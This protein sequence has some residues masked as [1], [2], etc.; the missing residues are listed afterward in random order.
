MRENMVLLRWLETA[1]SGIR[2]KP[3][4]EAVREELYAHLEDKTLDLQRIFPDIDP[5]EARDQALAG[6]GDAEEIKVRLARVHRP[7]LGYLWQ[8]SRWLVRG[9]LLLCLVLLVNWHAEGNSYSLQKDLTRL[10]EGRAWS[11]ELFGEED[12]SGER[13]ALFYPNL[14]ARMGP[15]TISIPKAALWPDQVEHILYLQ[16]RVTWD[17][18]WNAHGGTCVHFSAVDDQGNKLCLS[19]TN[20]GHEAG[21]LWRQ[22]NLCVWG[23]P[24]DAKWIKLTYL[25][26]A[27]GIGPEL[28]INLPQEVEP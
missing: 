28:I 23:F 27:P 17:R 20:W 11:E 18:P 16:L 2:F 12:P 1:V 14:E 3:D 10:D 13:L 22:Y 4:R 26:D 24:K 8:A 7:W 21:L 9:L 6:M 5:D 19:G 15:G 25:P